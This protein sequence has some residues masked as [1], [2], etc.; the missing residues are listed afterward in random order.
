MGKLSLVLLVKNWLP[1]AVQQLFC[2]REFW[3]G[4]WTWRSAPEPSK[5][6]HARHLSDLCLNTPLVYGTRQHRKKNIY[7]LE[8]IQRRAARFVMIRYNISSVS[9]MIET[10][11]W[12]SLEQR[13]SILLK[14]HTNLA[15]DNQIKARSTIKS[16]TQQTIPAHRMQDTIDGASVLPRT[17]KDWNGL[18]ENTVT[19]LTLDTFMSRVSK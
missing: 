6:E 7:K 3:E 12:Q 13:L 9:Q 1:W 8:S 11:G 4:T 19:A 2:S 16:F 5:R 18:Q 15:H 14:I 10:L 17:V